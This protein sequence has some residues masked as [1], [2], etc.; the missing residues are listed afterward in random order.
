MDYQSLA[1]HLQVGGRAGTFTQGRAAVGVVVV[2][3]VEVV[4]ALGLL[5]VLLL[6]PGA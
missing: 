4:A 3:V 2:V 5:L 6:F 1:D